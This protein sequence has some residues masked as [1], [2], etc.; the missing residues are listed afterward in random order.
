M[1]DH[2]TAA[3][4]RDAVDRVVAER[5]LTLVVVEHLVEPWVGLVDRVL[6]VVAHD[7]RSPLQSILLTLTSLDRLT[8]VP[9]PSLARQGKTLSLL[10]ASAHR[11]SRM[12]EDLLDV[13]RV[14]AGQLSI[15]VSPQAIEPLLHEALE[16]ARPQAGDIRLVC[17]TSG[18]LPAV[19]ADRDRLLQV[20]SNLLGNALKF[21][22]P[23]GEVRVGARLEDGQ[24]IC[25]V[26]DSGPGIEPEAQRHLFERFWQAQ[27]GDRRGAG[28]GLSIVKGIVEAHGGTVRVESARGEGSAFFFSVPLAPKTQE[29]TRAG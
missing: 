5:G 2:E 11:M 9:G 3:E 18:R 26:K 24:L 29:E 7:L 14:E 23:G 10:A 20:F 25:F 21:T 17:E 27:P 15:R 13:A 4:V 16:L 8:P 22:P 12:I 19:L 28:L 1:L 6:G